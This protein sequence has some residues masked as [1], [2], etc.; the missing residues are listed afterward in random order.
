MTVSGNATCSP[1]AKTSIFR[2]VIM[3]KS[4]KKPAKRSLKEK[5]AEKKERKKQQLK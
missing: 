2:R 3:A 4:E 5:R 1:E